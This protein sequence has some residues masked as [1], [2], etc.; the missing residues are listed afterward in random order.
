MI[1]LYFFK[2]LFT[3]LVIILKTNL[4]FIIFIFLNVKLHLIKI[5]AQEKY[6]TSNLVPS[7]AIVIIVFI[8]Y[9]IIQY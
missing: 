6:N 4:S 2:Q 7:M 5:G 9:I 8:Y 1:F 3:F